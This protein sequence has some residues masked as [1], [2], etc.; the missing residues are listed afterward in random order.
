[1]NQSANLSFKEERDG[2]SAI[3]SSALP[4]SLI[5]FSIG[6][7][8]AHADTV[9]AVVNLK[10]STSMEAL[11]R[12]V[13]D[14]SSRYREFYT[15]QEIREI[16]GSSDADHNRV[17]NQLKAA[18]AQILHESPTHLS[19]TIRAE[20]SALQTLQTRMS[21]MNVIS[22]VSGLQAS[23]ARHPHLKIMGRVDST[24]AGLLLIPFARLTTS[25]RS[26]NRASPVKAKTSRSQ[27]TTGSTSTTSRPT[28]PRITSPLDQAS[29]K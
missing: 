14:P 1:M 25:M 11:A 20:R 29:T 21:G 10:E 22:S 8:A 15:S 6:A 24:T 12:S 19:I 26:I 16:A 3:E 4:L 13:T 5:G 27:P 17:S 23:H 18:G 7:S 9:Q 2:T 28:I